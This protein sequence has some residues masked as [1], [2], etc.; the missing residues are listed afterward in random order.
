MNSMVGRMMMIL[1]GCAWAPTATSG[2]EPKGAEDAV[3]RVDVDVRGK[4]LAEMRT[5]FGELGTPKPW[6]DEAL[7]LCNRMKRPGAGP[8]WKRLP[9]LNDLKAPVLLRIA[10]T[11]ARAGDIRGAMATA[12]AIEVP[13][14]RTKALVSISERQRGL[15][16]SRRYSEAQEY[17]DSIRWGNRDKPFALFAI[18]EAKMFSGETSSANAFSGAIETSSGFPARKPGVDLDDVATAMARVAIQ[19]V[20]AGAYHKCQEI[21]SE[22]S[23]TQETP[24]L[25]EL[26]REQAVAGDA[27]GAR[28]TAQAI[29]QIRSAQLALA[30]V[31]DLC[32]SA[33]ADAQQDKRE[34]GLKKVTKAKRIASGIKEVL[35]AVPALAEVA[36]AQAAFHNFKEA[37][38]IAGEMKQVE[39]AFH[40][41]TMAEAAATYPLR[42]EEPGRVWLAICTAQLKADDMDGAEQTAKEMR[43]SLLDESWV[44]AE[45]RIAVAQAKSGDLS[46]AQRRLKSMPFSDWDRN[47]VKGNKL[48][49]LVTGYC[50]IAELLAPEMNDGP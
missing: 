22:L 44:A 25:I 45:C 30:D 39:R 15:S 48:P 35:Q 12:G 46:A 9:R 31:M 23:R 21:V 27:D 41:R 5:K 38:E 4:W 26:A 28:K 17:L 40:C 33:L 37:K 8:G 36:I 43:G 2:Q 49:L 42:T 29:R 3:K 11:Q 10:K 16:D 13:Y 34:D 50:E 14:Y 19:H 18:T 1:V 7:A 24:L 47:A 6:V 32:T 20:R